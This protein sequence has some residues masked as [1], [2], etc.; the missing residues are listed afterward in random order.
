MKINALIL[1]FTFCLSLVFVAACHNH[2]AELPGAYVVNIAIGKPVADQTVAK[3]TTMPIEV[4]ITRD[5]NATIHNAKFEVVDS[6][7]VSE[8][9]FEKH[10][11][12]DGK[13]TYSE[14]AYK[15]SKSGTFKLKV[16]VTDDAKAQPN[17]KE[18]SFKVN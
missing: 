7:G 15:P 4:V 10:Y 13:V 17:T 16:T 11:H 1:G 18:V 2:D 3:N 8:I 14:N 12:A 5:N 6:V 9:L